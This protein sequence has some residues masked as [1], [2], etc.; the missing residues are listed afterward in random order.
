MRMQWVR[1][2]YLSLSLVFFSFSISISIY[3]LS[4][5]RRTKKSSFN[6]FKSI[7]LD[8]VIRRSAI[9]SLTYRLACC[10]FWCPKFESEVEER[11]KNISHHRIIFWWFEKKKLQILCNLIC[12]SHRSN[13]RL[14]YTIDSIWKWLPAE[15]GQN[16]HIYCS[17]VICTDQKRGASRERKKMNELN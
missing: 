9:L 8:F 16:R 4:I 12:M 11:E 15:N 5:K 13:R 7:N 6:R 3:S 2:F 10:L 1:F 14:K 17:G